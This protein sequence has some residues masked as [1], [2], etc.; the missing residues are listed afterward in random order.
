MNIFL[1]DTDLEKC[2]QYHCD[3][4]VVKMPLEYAQLLSTTMWHKGLEGPYKLTHENH[5]CAI[6]CR[7]Y[8]GNYQKLWDL[9]ICVG[10]E[11]THRYG[12]VHKSIQL[13]LDGTIPRNI[14]S[15][16]EVIPTV[17]PLPNC[18]T[19]ETDP[20]YNL[21]DL[22]RLYYMTDK[23]HLLTYKNREEPKWMGDRFY[24]QQTGATV[25]C[26]PNRRDTKRKT[27][28]EKAPSKAELAERL[29]ISDLEKLL[30]K[31]LILLDVGQFNKLLT[32]PTGRLKAPYIAECKKINDKVDWSKLT[33]KT[34][35]QVIKHSNNNAQSK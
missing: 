5:P 11:Y 32:V 4:H 19:Y 13:L 31:D 10:K 1:L 24:Q 18:T 29:G 12:K 35:L 22:Y 25:G 7:A 30:T 15:W 23:S 34:L 3:K 28:T 20:R 27:V 26:L 21:V 17:S 6:W 2:A 8:K 16:T 14:E 33:V 9:A